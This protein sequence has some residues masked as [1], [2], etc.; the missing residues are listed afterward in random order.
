MK[1]QD[2]RSAHSTR[3]EFHHRVL[4]QGIG[5]SRVEFDVLIAAM[6]AFV[7]RCVMPVWA[8]RRS[9]SSPRVT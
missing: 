1:P 6:Q 2:R 9:S 4:Q 8:R 5:A 3:E 7:D